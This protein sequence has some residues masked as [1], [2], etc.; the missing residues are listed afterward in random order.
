MLKPFPVK[1]EKK[2]E[3]MLFY[4]IILKGQSFKSVANCGTETYR[5]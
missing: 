1:K 5:K 4:Q 3:L 2:T